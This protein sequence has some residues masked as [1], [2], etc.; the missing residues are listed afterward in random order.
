MTLRLSEDWLAVCVGQFFFALM[1][2]N[3]TLFH[4]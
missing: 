2:N 3:Q 1:L 4:T